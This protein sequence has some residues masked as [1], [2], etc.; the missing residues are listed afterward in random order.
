MTRFARIAD[1]YCLVRSM[2]HQNPGHDGGMHVCM[3]GHSNPEPDTPYYGSVMAR[4]RPAA[5][6]IPSYVWIQNL[7]GD[8]QPRYLTGGYLG[9]AY[10]PL[11]VGTDLDNPAAANFR[12]TAFDTPSDVPAERLHERC[13]LLSLLDHKQRA[14]REPSL[15]A[16]MKRFQARAVELVPGQA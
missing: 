8:V 9:A 12:M 7:A 10:S 14:P 16:S 6:N 11:R 2:S 3:T 4:L 13:R 1:Q 15:A 5:R